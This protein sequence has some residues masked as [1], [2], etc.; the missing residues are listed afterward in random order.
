[1]ATIQGNATWPG[2]VGFISCTMSIG[3]GAS[4]G[5]ASLE[6]PLQSTSSVQLYGTLALDDGV[7]GGVRFPGCKV[8][9]IDFPT[10]GGKRMVLHI[11]DRR[12]RWQYGFMRGEWNVIDPHPDV[13]LFPPGEFVNTQGPYT[14]GTYRTAGNL[15][16][17]CFRTLGENVM[18]VPDSTQPITAVWDEDTPIQ[19]VS[20]ICDSIDYRICM[21][22][23]PPD[24]TLI[25]PLGGAPPLI[26]DS[27]PYLPE[28]PSF[29]IG[30]QPAP[31]R[32]VGANTI[33]NDIVRLEP[34][35]MEP[36]GEI[37]A[38]NDL[39]YTPPNGWGNTCPFTFWE[40]KATNQIS[41]LTAREL[42][43][44]YIWRMFR[45]KMVDVS[46]VSKAGPNIG[47]YGVV[48]DRKQITLLPVAYGATKNINGERD[49]TPAYV[50]GSILI[51]NAGEALQAGLLAGLTS[52]RVGNTDPA[53]TAHLPR[54]PSIDGARGVVTF[55]RQCY[56]H[57]ANIGDRIFVYP[58]ELYLYT[59]MNIREIVGRVPVKFERQGQ[60]PGLDQGCQPE[61]LKHPEMVLINT[62]I[63]NNGT[64]TIRVVDDN[65]ADL[66]PQANYYLDRAAKKYEIA[67]SLTR[68]YPSIVP[69]NLTGNITQITWSVGG[70]APCMTTV[71]INSEHDKYVSPYAERRRREIIRSFAGRDAVNGFG[72]GRDFGGSRHEMPPASIYVPPGQ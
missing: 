50:M 14:P 38:I 25:A 68:R 2:V 54:T 4:P 26:P 51:S 32:V 52:I 65:S 64:H 34:C 36:D 46:D 39:S 42:A 17:D 16:R 10:E 72:D 37:K 62:T 41:Q 9:S 27:I 69:I 49:S 1:M 43:Q 29:S 57:G 44:K 30:L 7:S 61:I 6:V 3:H 56:I 53:G 33:Y 59:G 47:G 66:I 13:S 19:A 70:G 5:I 22:T 60:Q 20:S 28:S 11:A 58:P 23:M 48:K 24:L 12:W 40:A 35:G 63:R 21:Q 15:I 55:D 31:L 18:V 45:V 67:A 71:S 8:M